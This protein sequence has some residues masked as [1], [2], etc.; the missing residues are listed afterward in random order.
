MTLLLIVIHENK[1]NVFRVSAFEFVFSSSWVL[2]LTSNNFLL[3][4]WENLKSHRNT[5]TQKYAYI[6]RDILPYALLTVYTNL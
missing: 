4:R 1:M 6:H 5:H 2:F 3:K